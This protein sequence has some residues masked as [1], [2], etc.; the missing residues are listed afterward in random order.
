MTNTEKKDW[1]IE[2]KRNAKTWLNEDTLIPFVKDLIS[3]AVAE[4][5]ERM[6]REIKEMAEPYDGAKWLN[7]I[8]PERLIKHLASLG[9]NPK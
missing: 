2:L 5:R 3:Q 4:E 1:E 8:D 7:Q 9:S 6:V